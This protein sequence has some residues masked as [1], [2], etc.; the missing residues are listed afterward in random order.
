MT[1]ACCRIRCRARPSSM[2]VP[3]ASPRWRRATD[4]Q[5]RAKAAS[6]PTLPKASCCHQAALS[7][8]R[9]VV[10][11]TPPASSRSAPMACRSAR[12][13]ALRWLRMTPALFVLD[14]GKEATL[15]TFIRLREG[16]WPTWYWG[17]PFMPRASMAAARSRLRRRLSPSTA[18]PRR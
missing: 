11:S 14:R 17:E 10:M 7:T 1:L 13:A 4:Q 16:A 18:P 5:A 8:C 15:T 9:A 6:S 12:A 3:S 2:A